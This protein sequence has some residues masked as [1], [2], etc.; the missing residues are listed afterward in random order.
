MV[1][2]RAT[3]PL[4]LV[5]EKRAANGIA[6]VQGK[7]LYDNVGVV[8]RADDQEHHDDAADGSRDGPNL[9]VTKR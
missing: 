9:R 2:K 3:L 1:S 6:G 5:D 7:P 8:H 4:A